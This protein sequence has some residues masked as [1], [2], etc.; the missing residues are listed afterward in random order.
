MKNEKV[1]KATKI[2]PSCK[3]L[4][5]SK[6]LKVVNIPTLKYRRYRGHFD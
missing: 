3:G 4:I 2:V 5:Y 1:Q 6:R